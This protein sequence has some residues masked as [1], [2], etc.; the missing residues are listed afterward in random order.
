M[1]LLESLVQTSHLLDSSDSFQITRSTG[2]NNNATDSLAYKENFLSESSS[3][4]VEGSG[5][6]AGS[7]TLQKLISKTVIPK[8]HERASNE[9]SSG[10]GITLTKTPA[11]TLH[12]LH[13]AHDRGDD[14]SN[15]GT[16]T[17]PRA[18]IIL[19]EALSEGSLITTE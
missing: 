11:L 7:A 10:S 4:S 15:T 17:P 12:N 18:H 14:E 19:E 9:N 2:R 6:D 8:E 3:E 1:F 5:Y 13:S 16:G